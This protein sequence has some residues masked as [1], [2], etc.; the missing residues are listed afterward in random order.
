[1]HFSSVIPVEPCSSEESAART[2]GLSASAK[3]PINEKSPEVST[4][5]GVGG[6]VDVVDVVV[7]VDVDR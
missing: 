6:V 7:V 2:R 5:V 3:Q 4:I 1:M